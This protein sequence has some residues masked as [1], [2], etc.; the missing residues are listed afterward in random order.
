MP[1][2]LKILKSVT[3]V[4]EGDAAIGPLAPGETTMPIDKWHALGAHAAVCDG[5]GRGLVTVTH[6][7][8]EFQDGDEHCIGCHFTRAQAEAERKASMP[9]KAPAK[10]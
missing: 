3:V 2:P 10:P 9:V 8:H 6:K 1:T 7:R 5:I 4:V